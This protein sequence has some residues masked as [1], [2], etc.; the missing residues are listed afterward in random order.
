[1]N[2]PLLYNENP[3]CEACKADFGVAEVKPVALKRCL[4]S[5]SLY[6][7]TPDLGPDG[8]II[9]GVKSCDYNQPIRELHSER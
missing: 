3:Y 1:M 5:W 6:Y 9:W 7:P 8:R 2:E 4:Y